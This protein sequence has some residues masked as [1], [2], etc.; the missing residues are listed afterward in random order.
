MS[1]HSETSNQLLH[2]LS[3]LDGSAL[4][5]R[6]TAVELIQ[7]LDLA[8]AGEPIVSCWFPLS[9]LVSVIAADA[10]GKE[11]EVGVIGRE[12]MVNS[13]VMFGG[14]ESPMRVL[15]QIAGRALRVDAKYMVTVASKSEGVQSLIGA[16][17]QALAAQAAFSALAY[18]QYT[19]PK[20]LARWALM[21][22]DR[23]GDA[24]IGLTHDALSIMLGIR[25]ASITVAIQAL[26]RTGAIATRRGGFAIIDRAVLQDIAGAAYGPSEVEYRRVVGRHI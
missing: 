1:N 19:I 10:D 8:R 18:A 16:Y 17:G 12:G 7:G 25:R 5:A 11:A 2:S 20:R 26:A 6:T 15:V 9:G 4:A 3:E 13:G 24:N 21:C 23:V 22:G 14:M